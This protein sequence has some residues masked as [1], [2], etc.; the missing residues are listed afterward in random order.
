[1]INILHKQKGFKNLKFIHFMGVWFFRNDFL[2]VNKCFIYNRNNFRVFYF[3]E[4]FFMFLLFEN[5]F[6][7]YKIKEKS[8]MFICDNEDFELTFIPF[9]LEIKQYYVIKWVDGI[10]SNNIQIFGLFKTNYPRIMPCT[11]YIDKLNKPKFIFLLSLGS[12]VRKKLL[13]ECSRTN[14]PVFSLIFTE[15]DIYLNES[16]YIVCNGV[17]FHFL[18]FFLKTI[19]N[20]MRYL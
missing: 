16:Y 13:L 9:I 18:I 11:N 8:L 4:L 20:L 12:E 10:L 14:V 17:N 19:R 5:L 1:M 7:F 6:N 3:K 15:E 2:K